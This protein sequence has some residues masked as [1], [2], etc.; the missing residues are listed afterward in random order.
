MALVVVVA[1]SGCLPSSVHRAVTASTSAA[2]TPT[3]RADLCSQLAQAF[4]E[5][6]A[7]GDAFRLV[8]AGK[9]EEAIA[10]AGL[11]RQRLDALLAD[12]PDERTPAE[13]QRSLRGVVEASAH[14]VQGTA[15][16]IDDPRRPVP[17]AQLM[18]VEGQTLL[19]VIDAAFSMSEPGDTVSQACPGLAFTAQPVSFPPRPSPADL[20]LPDRVGRIF[21]EPHLGR[22]S[23]PDMVEI[24][25]RLGARPDLGREIDVDAAF[26]EG[27]HLQI[28]VYDGVTVNP[29]DFAVA[30]AG[31]L[32]TAGVKPT[33]RLVAGFSV[34]AFVDRD[35][36]DL[37]LHVA[38]RGDRLLVFGG[39]SDTDVEAILA[40]M[41]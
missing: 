4:A 9:V 39:F 26:V 34:T 12:L 8:I 35:D 24:L 28:E 19:G 37:S 13:P 14:L 1:L 10:A 20:G 25:E 5:R 7:L 38:S 40:A 15:E 2:P 30:I 17:D 36:S 41:P 31:I 18:L 3:P 33:E 21:F 16:I 11:I 32:A 22:I 29:V 6:D 23:N 27:G